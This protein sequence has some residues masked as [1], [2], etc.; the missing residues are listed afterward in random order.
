MIAFTVSFMIRV[1][2]RDLL[3]SFSLLGDGK[4]GVNGERVSW[5]HLPQEQLLPW[6]DPC[7]S[8]GR[9]GESPAS[10]EMGE[11]VLAWIHKET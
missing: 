1:N 9:D 8:V 7:W 10:T 3:A 5:E 2:E 4:V 6:G 11:Q